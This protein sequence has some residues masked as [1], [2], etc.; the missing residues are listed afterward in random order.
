MKNEIKFLKKKVNDLERYTSKDCVIIKSLPWR[1]STDYVED[2]I[3]LFREAIDINVPRDSMVAC[4]PV[5]HI[6]DI[7]NPP[8]IIVKFLFFDLKDRIWA[9]MFLNEII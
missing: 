9:G 6:R 7:Q 2:E 1:H 4:H 5:G 3:A 8:A